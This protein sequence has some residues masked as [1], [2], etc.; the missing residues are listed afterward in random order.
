MANLEHLLP[1]HSEEEYDRM[2]S[3]YPKQMSIFPRQYVRWG[4]VEDSIL[5][6]LFGNGLAT[7]EICKILNRGPGAI[8]SRRK[9]LG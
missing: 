7:K 8:R 1:R 6:G 3:L 9:K 5:A 2:C 4:E